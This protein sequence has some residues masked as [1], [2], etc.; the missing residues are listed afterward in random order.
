MMTMNQELRAACPLSA[1]IAT[2]G[3]IA[4]A[5]GS[6]PPRDVFV[7][8]VG[9]VLE[10]STGSSHSAPPAADAAASPPCCDRAQLSCPPGHLRW[11]AA[12]ERGGHGRDERT[13]ADCAA[14][15]LLSGPLPRAY[16]MDRA[17]RGFT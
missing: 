5:L 9:A 11:V 1:A 13:L 7:V 17:I 2:A 6:I 12:R 4:S 14:P 15:A 8:D 3:T 10:C 16:T